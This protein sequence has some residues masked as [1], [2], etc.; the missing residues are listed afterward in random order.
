[1]L[2][3]KSYKNYGFTLIELL[4]VI[5]ILAIIALIS[6]PVIIGLIEDARYNALFSDADGIKR[7]VEYKLA[8]DNNYDVSTIN[9]SN[10]K[11]K[12]NIS[13][14]NFDAVGVENNNGKI[15]VTVLRNN[16]IQTISSDSTISNAKVYGLF[17]DGNNTFV[18]TDDA[19][20]LTTVNVGVDDQV[21]Q[22]DFDTAEI[23]SEMVEVTDEYGNQFIKIP[24]FYIKKTVNG[25]AW[26]WQVSKSKKDA[27]YYLPAC[28]IDET[29]GKIL[30]YILVGKY[31]ASL[32]SDSTK[33]ESKT[34][35][36]PVVNK[37]IIHFRNYAKANGAG[38]QLFDIHAIDIIQTLFYIEFATVNSQSI[39]AGYT[40]GQ[41]D[42]THIIA[43]VNGNTITLTNGGS[44]YRVGQIIDV[45]TS[46]GNRKTAKNLRV[47]AV[48]DNDITY[49]TITGISEMKGTI[50]ADNI[51]YNVAY[52]N[53]V[54][55]D[56]VASSGSNISNIDGKYVM[57]Y[58]GIENIYG[59]LNQLVDGI[60]IQNQ[61]AYVARNADIYASDKFGN[62]Y[63]KIGY[64]LSAVEEFVVKMGYDKNNP[65][66]QL[67]I[68]VGTSS[69][70][71]YNDKYHPS[72]GNTAAIFGGRWS[73]KN[74]SGISFWN[75]YYSA[76]GGLNVNIGS[77]LM[78]TPI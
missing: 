47:T 62:E 4:A 71:K 18:R 24:K 68:T 78:K 35:T 8:N 44:N 65:F 11:T 51:V 56:V 31:N 1:M 69:S 50:A 70:S 76:S 20:S 15:T 72:L 41:Y 3:Y 77:R 59:N 37:N 66:I 10:L 67:A 21:V 16:M 61:E 13:N 60:N 63:V 55:D 7:A 30:P 14:G 57:K 58:R 19:A 23:Y 40:N 27:D 33:L 28:F 36:V 74:T 38:Y 48:N 43:S 32:S 54:T 53:G 29:N 42:G 46:L 52:L 6:S 17:W 2:K 9:S 5:V 75:L 45:S 64:T 12:L 22:N 39:M 25:D 34:G 49:E 73:N 26:T